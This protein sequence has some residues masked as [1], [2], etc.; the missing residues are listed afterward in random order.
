MENKQLWNE[1]LRININ[2]NDDIWIN[3][4]GFSMFP[5]LRDGYKVHVKKIH[6]LYVGQIIIFIMNDIYVVHRIIKINKKEKTVVT[7]GDD[8]P[9]IDGNIPIANILGE[10][11][12]FRNLDNK[13]YYLHE[14]KWYTRLAVTLSYLVYFFSY[15]KRRDNNVA[16]LSWIRRNGLIMKINL[17]IYNMGTGRKRYEKKY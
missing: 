13:I 3:V 1:I 11:D 16:K 6:R 12:C 17:Y 9:I 8:V 4:H 7:I 15:I 2:N 5:L 10:V 14:F